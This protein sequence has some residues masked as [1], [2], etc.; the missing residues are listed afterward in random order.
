MR[1]LEWFFLFSFLPILLTPFLPQT[2]RR[3]WLVVAV[4]LPT[5]MGGLH[6][7]VEGWRIE[8]VPLYLFAV[9][10]LVSRLPVLLGRES[11]VRRR[12]G[13]LMSSVGA[14]LLVL[15]G[16]LAGWLVPVIELPSPTGPYH[17]GVVDREL[18]DQARGRR[19]MVTIWYPAARGGPPAPLT[20]YQDEW[21]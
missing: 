3:R 4:P 8:I 9:G 2:W 19:L 18:M 7:I 16:V 11:P 21:A 12:R 20:H 14:L 5:L 13:V 10:V 1:P 17:V 6:V 15:S